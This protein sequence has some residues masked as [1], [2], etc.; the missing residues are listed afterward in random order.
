V[1]K[2]NV[3]REKKNTGRTYELSALRSV[4]KVPVISLC[5]LFTAHCFYVRYRTLRAAC[6]YTLLALVIYVIACIL[7]VSKLCLKKVLNICV[8]YVRRLN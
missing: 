4:D 6:I 2:Y 3:F 8:R 1:C 5:S 7:H